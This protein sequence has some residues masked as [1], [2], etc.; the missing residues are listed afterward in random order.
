M[1]SWANHSEEVR[2]QEA[3]WNGDVH[4]MLLKLAVHGGYHR[5]AQLVDVVNWYVPFSLLKS[6]VCLCQSFMS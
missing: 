1:L 5:Q 3:A 6:R 2:A 4:S